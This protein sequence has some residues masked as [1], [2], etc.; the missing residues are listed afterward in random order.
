MDSRAGVEFYNGILVPGLVNAHCH[1][2]LSYL[3]GKIASGGG[4][5][6]FAAGIG[7]VRGE[8]SSVDRERAIRFCD[9]R[10]RAEGIVAVGDICNGSSTF[11][12]KMQSEIFYH[13]FIEVFGLATTSLQNA[14]KT[15]ALSRAMGITA[16]VSPHSTYS[17]QDETFRATIAASSGMPDQGDLLSIHFMESRAEEELFHGE[18]PLAAWYAHNRWSA[19][20]LHYGS[21]TRRVESCVPAERRVLLIHNTFVDE[22]TVDCLN[23]R[24]GNRVTWVLCPRSNRFIEG[25]KPPVALLRRKGGRIAVGTDSLASNTDLSLIEELKQFPDVPFE[26]ILGWATQSGA[27]A[28]GLSN[29]L[30]QFRPGMSPG[31]TLIEGIDWQTMRLGEG[32]KSRRLI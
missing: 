14:I 12:T 2:E 26:E 7:A 4:F 6:A 23:D 16:S 1:L 11:G 27:E 19:D 9:A 17:L 5:A 24:F 29:T 22:E 10:M 15:A 25:A 30:G 18:G 32:A 20:F 8:T 13:N 28:L 21:P 3:K 31:V